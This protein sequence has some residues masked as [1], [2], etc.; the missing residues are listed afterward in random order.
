MGEQA[1]SRRDPE[2]ERHWRGLMAEWRRSG[3]T[4]RA[5]CRERGLN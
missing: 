1:R 2:R 3:M 4:I 5:F